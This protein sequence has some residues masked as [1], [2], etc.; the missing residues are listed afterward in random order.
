MTPPYRPVA[1]AHEDPP[2]AAAGPAARILLLLIAG[3]RRLISPFLPPSCRFYPSCSK[4]AVIAIQK[5][6]AVRGLWLA[7]RRIARCHPWNPGG[8]D[9][10][11]PADERTGRTSSAP[12][13]S[14]RRRQ[15]LPAGPANRSVV[16][17]EG[18]ISCRTH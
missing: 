2:A 9:P 15:A 11:P 10:V 3:Y 1:S 4:Y 16:P 8:F 14:I 7:L 13:T 5:H 12:A 17:D 18:V 6:G